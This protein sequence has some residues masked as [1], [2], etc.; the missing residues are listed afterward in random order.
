MLSGKLTFFGVFSKV[1]EFFLVAFKLL[2]IR[3]FHKLLGNLRIISH[4]ERIIS[5]YET[6]QTDPFDVSYFSD[7]NIEDVREY[8]KEMQEKTNTK[9]GAEV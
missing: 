3:A 6:L 5:H 7:M 1:P 8:E 2:E 9:V 4:Y